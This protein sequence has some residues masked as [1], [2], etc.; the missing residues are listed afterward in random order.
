[1]SALQKYRAYRETIATDDARPITFTE[2]WLGRLAGKLQ[3]VTATMAK[4]RQDYPTLNHSL[5]SVWAGNQ[6][7]GGHLVALLPPAELSRAMKEGRL[8]IIIDPAAEEVGP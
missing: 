2:W 6:S 8:R 5:L 4:T 7:H 3:V 1:M